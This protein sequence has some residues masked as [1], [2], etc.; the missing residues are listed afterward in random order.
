MKKLLSRFLI[1]VCVPVLSLSLAACGGSQNPPEPVAP[2]EVVEPNIEPH[3]PEVEPASQPVSAP[4][5]LS[6]DIYSFM[7][8]LN[9]ATFTL[10]FPYAEFESNG[11]VG[12]GLETQT[13]NPN[14]FTLSTQLNNADQR[15]FVS[16][17][18]TT[19][20]ITTLNESMVGRITIDEWEARSGVELVFP[21]NISIGSSYE[22]V[23][24]AHGEPSERSETGSTRRLDYSSSSRASVTISVDI[25]SGLVNRIQM[26]NFIA[27]EISPAFEGDVPAAVSAYVAPTE[28]GEDWRTFNVR[29][30]GDLY[31]LPAP[32]AAFVANGWIIE[33]DPNEMVP[34]RSSRTGIT[35]RNGN[36]TMR[37]MVENYD[38]SAQPVANTFVTSV[39]FS[40][41]GAVLPIELPGGITENSTIEEVLAAFGTPDRVEESASFRT[42]TF[43]SRVFERIEVGIRLETSE[44]HRID[45]RNAP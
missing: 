33:G 7:F 21:G 14:Q 35:L 17:V 43:G 10:P 27:R 36:Q 30:A 29:F 19:D 38:D 45:V 15:I 42:Y 31:S 37:T 4:G 34:A 6:E 22:D 8:G 1:I 32:V 9:G 41:F 5:D 28:L 44:I 39:E 25:E 24:A 11:W 16:F 13:L 12:E 2:P 40:H 26:E 23:I 20:N 3:Q 18:N